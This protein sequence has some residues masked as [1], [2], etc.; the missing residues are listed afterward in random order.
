[1]IRKNEQYIIRQTIKTT[2]AFEPVNPKNAVPD[3]LSMVTLYNLT[4]RNFAFLN[5]APA[6]HLFYPNSVR[7]EMYFPISGL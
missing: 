7:F 3:L 6:I 2:I 4:Q 5:L 1:M